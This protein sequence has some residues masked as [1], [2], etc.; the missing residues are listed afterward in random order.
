MSPPP[1]APIYISDLDF[2]LRG[3]DSL[4]ERTA[5]DLSGLVQS[6]R[7]LQHDI[8][9]LKSEAVTLATTRRSKPV[10]TARP[11]RSIDAIRHPR[12]EPPR[13]KR[14]APAS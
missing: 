6:V 1:A 9:L 12:I 7:R 13:K 5:A 11:V 14:A 8:A 3:I 4:T 2:L 10:E